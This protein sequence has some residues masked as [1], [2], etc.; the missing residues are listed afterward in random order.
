[1]DVA[2]ESREEKVARLGGAHDWEEPTLGTFRDHCSGGW[3]QPSQ[4]CL[5]LL[6]RGDMA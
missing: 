3:D 5:S 2:L 4:V 6:E 1:M